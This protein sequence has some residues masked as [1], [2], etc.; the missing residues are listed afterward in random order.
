M[1]GRLNQSHHHGKRISTVHSKVGAPNI[2]TAS[3][4]P[5]FPLEL[6]SKVEGTRLLGRHA[7]TGYA[8][9]Q[10]E[11]DYLVATPDQR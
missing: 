7:D 10:V 8:H 3:H 4:Q 6:E 9:M 1:E 5:H 11:P 2:S